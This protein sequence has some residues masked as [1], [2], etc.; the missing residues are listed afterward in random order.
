M[1]LEEEEQIVLRETPRT[2]PVTYSIQ[3]KEKM[4]S[5]RLRLVKKNL[6]KITSGQVVIEEC[7]NNGFKKIKEADSVKERDQFGNDSDSVD[8]LDSSLLTDGQANRFEDSPMN[9]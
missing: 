9:T 2:E 4:P 6:D 7:E 5:L 3:I 1:E 8:I